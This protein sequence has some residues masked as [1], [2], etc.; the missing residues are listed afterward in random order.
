MT[1]LEKADRLGG[2]LYLAAIPP[3]RGDWLHEINYLSHEMQRLG[4]RVELGKEADVA[5]LTSEK[6]DAVVIAT[7]AT[8]IHPDIPGID[9]ENVVYASDVLEGKG[10]IGERVV[11]IGGGAIGC[12]TALFLAKQGTI[13]PD[14]AVFL[15][16]WGAKDAET[17]VRLTHTGNKKVTI[18]EMLDRIGKDI[19][20]GTRWTI[21]QSLRRHNVEMIRVATA[22]RITESGVEYI[23]E[24]EEKL[25]QADTVVIAVGTQSESGLFEAVKDLIPEVY[26]VGDCIQARTALEAIHEAAQLGRQI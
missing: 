22:T 16:S 17:A 18:L 26:R 15:A 25:A 7:G 19:N 6:P 1:L 5:L 10:E 9:R 21:M 13:N 11:I 2:Q 8:P 20:R 24:G 12:E 23:L 14:I 3:E 4:V